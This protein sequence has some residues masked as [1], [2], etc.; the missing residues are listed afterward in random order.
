MGNE[1]TVVDA[2]I[3]AVKHGRNLLYPT[4]IAH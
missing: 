3:H 4:R 1:F 2:L